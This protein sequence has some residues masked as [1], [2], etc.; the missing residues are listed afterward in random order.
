M[1]EL[2]GVSRDQFTGAYEAWEQSIHPEDVHQA[3]EAIRLAI[4]GEK[5]FDTMF[6]AVWSDQS[7]HYIQARATV[8]RDESGTPIRMLGTNSDITERKRAEQELISAREVAESATRAKS[9]FLAV[10]SHEIRTPMNAIIGMADLLWESSL[11]TTQRQYVEIFRRNGHTLLALINDILD[12]SKIEAGRFEL[13][14][15]PFSL[16]DVL[17]QALE[18]VAPRARTKGLTLDLDRQPS[19]PSSLVG[20]PMRLGQV[21]GNLLG[22]AVKFTE[23]GGLVLTVSQPSSDDPGEIAFAVVDSGP[24]IPPDQLERVFADFTQA[25]PSTTRNFG[26]TGLGLGI[27]RRLVEQMGGRLAVTSTVGQ[28]SAFTFSARFAVA[29][30]QRV[31]REV[32]NL[33]GCRVLLIDDDAI[34]RLV[35]R[36]TL[37]VWGAESD[38]FG[39]PERALNELAGAVA[40]RRPYALAIV[41]GMM[42]SMDGFEAARQI[43]LLAPDLPVVMLASDT[44]RGDE[45]RRLQAGIAG[46]ALKPIN[47][48]EL[49]R[50]ITKAM[51][52][53]VG[54]RAPAMTATESQAGTGLSILVAE[55]FA[56]NRVVIDAYLK[57]SPHTITFADHGRHAVELFTAGKFDLVLMDMQMP[58]MDGLDAT[59]AIRAL[60]LREARVPT[61]ILAFTANAR[62]EDVETT[63][64]AGCND[65]LSKPIAKR[66]LLQAIARLGEYRSAPVRT[67]TGAEATIEIEVPEGLAEFAPAYL[68]DRRRDVTHA[69][70]LLASGDFEGLTIVAHNMAGSGGLYGFHLLSELGAALEVSA[71]AADRVGV[72]KHLQELR[73]YMVRLRLP[74]HRDARGS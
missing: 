39:Q 9:G 25:D 69:A 51:G 64:R 30:P 36:E 14:A 32:V 29:P 40:E 68:E 58:V 43:R 16:D 38:D 18:L 53:T 37:A 8:L 1:Y 67:S 57:G 52:R 65:H 27:S 44:A 5:P 23:R 48:P 49:L 59:R 10:M 50:V 42:P 4:S 7:V 72:E 2:Y 41:D 17:R 34:N 15:E 20:D 35:L 11:D 31:P 47:R 13:D 21:L 33:E 74:G 56:D 61:P 12:L 3:R 45:R 46:F 54:A 26:G 19:V 71:R 6:R 62:P 70:A 28:G 24:G 73:K 63:R 55:D 22:N 66:A 60:E